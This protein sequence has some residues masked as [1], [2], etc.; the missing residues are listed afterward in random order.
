MPLVNKLGRFLILKTRS[1][2]Y[3][4]GFH[5]S[6]N[7]KE[8]FDETIEEV[9]MIQAMTTKEIKN[10]YRP[11]FQENYQKYYPVD[12]F[13]K[14]NF[15]R[16]KCECCGKFFWNINPERKKCADS[17][18]EGT[19][20]FIG[21]GIG[22]GKKKHVTYEDAWN[23]FEE[24]FTNARI[25]CTKIDRYPTV[26][27]WRNDVDYVAAGIYCFQPYCVTGE[28]A[29]PANPLICP[30]FCV[31]FNDL[32]NIGLT[33]RHYSGF[34]MIGIQVFNYP[35]E[36]H[37]FK[38]E[39][40]E[41]N[42]NWL[43]KGLEIP[44]EEI[45]FTE[46][47]WAG[48]GNMGP[49]IEYFVKGMEI[50]N[51][52]FMQYKTF[53]DGS[54]E[55][56]KVKVIDTGIGLERIPWVLNGSATSYT[57]TFKESFEYITE[58]LG[59]T[60]ENDVWKKLGPYSCL[61]DVDECEDMDKTWEHI[62]QTLKL[63]KAVIQKAIAPIRDI[64]IILDHTRS[65]FFLIRDGSLPS[66]VGGGSNLRNLIRRTFAIMSK[67]DWWS[68]C[69]FD[70]YLGLFE[71]HRRDMEKL[72]GKMET[73]SSFN[74]IMTLE[75][76]RWKN[77][78]GTQKS[79]LKKL[80][81]KRKGK[82]RQE[83]WLTA[84][85][86]WGLPP[87]TISELSKTPIPDN[88][89]YIISEAQERVVKATEQI[90]YDTT[91]LKETTCLYYDHLKQLNKF[92]S[93]FKFEA[94]I[95][96]VYSNVLENNKTNILILDQSGFYPTSGG[97]MHD[98]GFFMIKEKKYNITNIEKVGNCILHMIDQE[99][100]MEFVGETVV[101][102]I[103]KER[104]DQLRNHHTS[105]HIIFAAAREVL[106]P[107]VWQQGAKKTTKQAHL[108]VTHYMSVT[109]EQELKIQEAANRIVMKS[110]NIKKT[111][112]M[113]DEAEKEHGFRLYQGGIVPGNELRVV[114]IEGVDVEACCGT[115]CD[116]TSEVGWI[117]IITTKRIAD[118]IVRI[119]F[120]AGERTLEKLREETTIIND[121]SDM[122]N[123]PQNEIV[124]TASKFFKG[125]KRGNVEISDAKKKILD[126]QVKLVLMGTSK[127]G[128]IKSGEDN[129]TLYYSFLG[130]YA[131][132]LKEKEKA[133]VFYGDKF[134]F[135]FFPKK[136]SFNVNKLKEMVGEGV[137]VKTRN[138]FGAKKKQ[139]KG[140]LVVSLVGKQE[141]KDVKGM[142]S[143]SGLDDLDL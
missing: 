104:R 115:H 93:D 59:I 57:I 108:D 81:S 91:N 79:K 123:I 138:A 103:D 48:G 7:K 112:E 143:E 43:T 42:F 52:V 130:N 121:L 67:N 126:L 89:Y 46:D 101:G 73:Y 127:G 47:I 96:A 51:M 10:K 117:K 15:V 70:D 29:P 44:V 40:V 100:P 66:N 27:R 38:E 76:D 60:M 9:K 107:H 64:F 105:A 39:C 12:F 62:S 1:L 116:N 131:K 41:F 78:D 16:R 17:S 111:L 65:A 99:V 95:I 69:T 22:I 140:C 49:C 25:P 82:L 3:K 34:I 124:K 97:Q 23:T 68:V 56:L 94:K 13:N 26:A 102:E 74:E 30:Q 106:G 63:D 33:G 18:C 84:V 61:L 113:K 77:S 50:G 36:Y 83:D 32:D 109:K 24:S 35:N 80:L 119:Y 55:E 85:T 19:Y 58:K 125:Y 53:H 142:F 5:M 139:V 45:V 92:N 118:G 128:I 141:L 132:E 137:D 31:R 11:E 86:S 14:I 37:F 136:D 122:W 20:T 87:D 90:L 88:L 98:T 72:Y 135:G 129:P 28:M 8:E 75:Y 71:C 2:I 6:T 110:V 21:E 114:E 54:I 120:V 133:I 134:A 4:S